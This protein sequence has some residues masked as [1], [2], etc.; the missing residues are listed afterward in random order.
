MN[1][2]TDNL[3]QAPSDSLTSARYP[4][5]LFFD[6]QCAFCNRWVNK[7]MQADQAHRIRFGTKQGPTFQ[8]VVVPDHPELE[9][10]ESVVLV[11]R[12]AD[13]TEDFLVRSAA[14]REVIDGLKP[15]R[16]FELVLKICPTFLS[17]IGYR[18][19]SKLRAPLFGR[20]SHCRVPLE[21]EKVLF[22]D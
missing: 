14:I 6:G 12:R 9:K 10:V 18:I 5:L 4:M 11:V 15:F 2:Q 13:G 16:L 21:K 22:V 7:V 1:A 20:W 8:H 19:F 17:D 3:P